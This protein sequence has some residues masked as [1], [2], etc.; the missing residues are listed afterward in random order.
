MKRTLL[1]L[2]GLAFF[3]A[4]F[5]G[6]YYAPDVEEVER[7]RAA[8][9]LAPG[10]IQPDFIERSV[11]GGTITVNVTIFGGPIDI[12]VMDQEWA[13]STLNPEGGG[14]NLSQP[15][16]YHAQWSR[17][18]VTGAQSWTFIAD[19]ET[20]LAFVLDNSDTYYEDTSPGDEDVRIHIK[21]RYLEEEQRSL[22]YGYL[23]AI[24][25]VLLVVLT[26]IKQV[27]KRRSAVA[28]ARR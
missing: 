9:S 1:A 22:V 16:S 21:T 6:L 14:M 2:L 13:S 15:F 5:A 18:N 12:Y 26:I 19:G 24:P 3:A 8:F 28:R 23:A 7:E 27:R 20:R 10:E 25:S 4:L 17:L 11:R